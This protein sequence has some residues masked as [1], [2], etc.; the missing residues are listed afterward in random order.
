MKNKSRYSR[1]TVL[2]EIGDVGQEKIS[3]ASILCVGAGGL[4]CPALLYL[5]AAGVGRIGIIDFDTV[6]ETNLQRQVLYTTDQIG[7]NK[8]VAAKERLLALN[9]GITVETYAEE[10]NGGNAEKL[11]S[12]Y[13]MIIDGTDN[14]AAKFL[15]ND[16]AVKMDKP[17]IYGAILGFAGQVSVFTPG[18]PCYRCLFPDAPENVPNCAEAGVIGAVA[19]IIGMTQAME[20]LKIIVGHT[21]FDPLTGKLWTIDL[22]TMENKILSLQK[23]PACPV[24]SKG[25]SEIMPSY[26]SPVCGSIP[27]ITPAQARDNKTA[28]L[29]D[30]R[31]REEWDTGYVAG[32]RHVALSA[33]MQGKIPDL[34]TEGDIILYCQK[35]KRSQKAAEILRSQGYLNVSSVSGGYDAW[36]AL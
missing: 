33:L 34:P 36:L 19:G 1:Q 30:V 29:I 9:P 3:A 14:F 22:R 28:L 8:A 4:G 7:K 21:S 20:A 10:L 16:V 2:S 5:A 13:D 35:G 25:K 24:C 18:G 17:F 27:E 12:N 6:N 23:N 32:A 26:S 15:M 11:F 31:E